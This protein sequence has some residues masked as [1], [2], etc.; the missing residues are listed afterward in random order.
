MSS[1]IGRNECPLSLKGPYMQ[2]LKILAELS[3]KFEKRCFIKKRK[4]T[5][6]YECT[7]KS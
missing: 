4:L 7:Y 5:S 3:Q 1:M 6:D 2:N